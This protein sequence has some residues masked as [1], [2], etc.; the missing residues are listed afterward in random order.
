MPTITTK[1]K[2]VGGSG[3]GTV[4]SVALT[5]PGIFSVSGSPITSSGTLVVS[6]ANQSANRVWAGPATGADAA[7]TFRAL[8]AADIP[9]LSS[10]YA[11]AGHSHSGVYSPV[12]HTHAQSDITNLVSDL[13]G[14]ASSSHTHAQSDITNL[15][16]DLAGKQPLDADLTAIAALSGT[17]TIYYRSAA[18]TW[19]AVTVG[20]NLSFTGGTLNLAGSIAVTGLR[21]F[22]TGGDHF[23]Q[24]QSGENLS[25]SRNLTVILNNAARTL[26]IAGDATISGTNT[27]DQTLTSLGGTTVG[28][29]VFTLTNPS[30]ISWPRIN[31]DNTVTARSASETR[32]DLSLASARTR[33]ITVTIDGGGSAL[34]T[35]T[36]L[37]MPKIPYAGTLISWALAADQSGSVVIDIWKSGSGIPTNGNTITASAKPTLSSQQE[38]DSTSLTGWTTSISVGDRFGFEVES[39]TTITQVTIVLEVQTS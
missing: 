31:A 27:G 5:V 13:A 7:P 20:S 32:T 17:N 18:D 35:G 38:A 11:T 9:D 36:K 4:T 1:L 14:K 12:G 29:N 15:T 22:D 3:S 26:T 30:A 6:V 19:T 24:I 33:T 10:V 34:T 23:F 16:T 2:T 25:A 21:I 39:A 28:Q 37:I 8:V